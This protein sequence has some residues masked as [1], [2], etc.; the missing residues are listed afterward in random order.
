MLK[1]VEARLGVANVS[2]RSRYQ[3]I[4]RGPFGVPVP[5]GEYLA[6]RNTNGHRPH[7]STINYGSSVPFVP[8]PTVPTTTRHV[9]RPRA[10]TLPSLISNHQ[11][12]FDDARFDGSFPSRV[13]PFLYLG[14]L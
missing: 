2:L 4:Q 11:T 1:K 13:L 12:W 5:A 9:G 8:R 7:A 3:D 14:N 10:N 6:P